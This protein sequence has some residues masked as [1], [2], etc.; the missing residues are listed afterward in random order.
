MNVSFRLNLTLD[1]LSMSTIYYTYILRCNDDTKY[2]GHTNNLKERIIDHLQGQVS[3]TKNKHPKLIYFEEV[4]SRSEAFKRERQ[5][6]NGNTRKATIEK[7]V[8]SFSPRKCQG[9]NSQALVIK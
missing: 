2:Y 5:L 9:F 8:N 7:L 3:Y 6:K 1:I 4:K